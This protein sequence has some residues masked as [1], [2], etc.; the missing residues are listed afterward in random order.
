MGKS[1]TETHF[2]SK[3]VAV[4]LLPLP[5]RP[6]AL[7]PYCPSQNTDKEY[8]KV[9]ERCLVIKYKLKDTYA[10]SANFAPLD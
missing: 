2:Y 5:T 1:G 10:A 3:R 8:R 7:D 6:T 9:E 4:S